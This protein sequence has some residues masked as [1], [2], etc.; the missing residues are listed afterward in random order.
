VTHADW[1]LD[2]MLASVLPLLALRLVTGATL[3]SAIVLFIALGLL[4]ALAW[5]RLDAIDVALVEAAVGAGLT[6]ALL[7]SSLAWVDERHARP[8]RHRWPRACL[9]MAFGGLAVCAGYFVLKLRAPSSGLSADVLAE[10]DRSGASHPITAILLNF[11]GYDTLLEVAVLLVAALAVRSVRPAAAGGD[12]RDGARAPDLLASF[13]SLL[14]PLCILVAGYLLWEGSHAPG[15][16]FQAAAVLAGGGVVLTLARRMRVPRASSLA[17]RGAVVLGPAL[18][19]VLAAEPLLTGGRL[20]EYPPAW[21]GALMFAIEA[22]LTISIAV[23]LVMFFPPPPR[24]KAG[25]SRGDP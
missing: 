10:M 8:R 22:A 21:A 3:E 7:M 17:T 4:S 12:A 11:R 14:V 24:P 13:V 6:G 1:L 5:A 2:T 9:T 23:M 18:F 19:V 20:L 15:G 16:A 25:G